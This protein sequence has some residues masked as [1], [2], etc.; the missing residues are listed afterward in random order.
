VAK[1]TVTITSLADSTANAYVNVYF[2]PA[3]TDGSIR[4]NLGQ[5]AT[6]YTDHLG[7]VWWGQDISRAFNS[8]YEIGWWHWLRISG[9]NMAI[10]CN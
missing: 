2:I 1:T 9:R 4:L 7:K 10:T 8:T 5:H 6:S 3:S